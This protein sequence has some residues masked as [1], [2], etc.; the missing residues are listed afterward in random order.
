MQGDGRVDVLALIIA[1]AASR[2]RAAEVIRAAAEKG[3]ALDFCSV[4]DL[5]GEASYLALLVS[6][7]RM[8]GAEA[9]S[10]LADARVRE[11][12][13][14]NIKAALCRNVNGGER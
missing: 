12:L 2:D 6:A 7:S 5:V 11:W 10:R 9:A 8:L 14:A 13:K 3:V 4:S 1:A